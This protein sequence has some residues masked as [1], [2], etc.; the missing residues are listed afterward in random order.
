MD[1]LAGLGHR[2]RVKVSGC[3]HASTMPPT[4]SALKS[5]NLFSLLFSSSSSVRHANTILGCC[6]LPLLPFVS[7]YHETRLDAVH[8]DNDGERE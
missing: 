7:L 2:W 1:T 4:L 8:T 3:V 6:S 5:V